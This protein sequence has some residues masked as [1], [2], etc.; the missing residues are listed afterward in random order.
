MGKPAQIRLGSA[1]MCVYGFSLDHH[2]HFRG[3]GYLIVGTQKT[4]DEQIFQL[5]FC[6]VT[7]PIV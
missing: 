4:Q 1:L 2:L 5:W 3:Y 6:V 7:V